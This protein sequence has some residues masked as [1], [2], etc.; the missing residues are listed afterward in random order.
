MS[1]NVIQLVQS[2]LTD[3]VVRRVSG[4]LG[5]AP[6]ATQKVIGMLAPTLVAAMMNKGATAEGARSLFAMITSPE[7][8]A[9]FETQLPDMLASTEGMSRLESTGRRLEQMTGRPVD[10]LS[11]AVATRTGV[12]AHSTHALTGIV[13]AALFG[14]LRRHFVDGRGD[15]SQ[16]PTLLG[17][18]LPA[19]S[20]HL[21]DDLLSTIGLGGAAGLV[22]SILSQLKLA[23]SQFA[24][25]SPAVATTAGAH[26]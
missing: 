24:H 25:L 6:E 4:R 11:D 8:N 17:H 23:S 20:S 22:S 10:A 3:G 9:H 26:A 12:A 7:A 19:I 21:S 18:Q 2:A 1:I 15:V 5:L 14:V 16:L 13:G